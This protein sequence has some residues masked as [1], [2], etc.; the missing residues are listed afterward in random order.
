MRKRSQN[1][2]RLPFTSKT[3]YS[4]DTGGIL[5][6]YSC[7]RCS[8]TTGNDNKQK[9]KKDQID[10]LTN[11]HD[12]KYHST[13]HLKGLQF[14]MAFHLSELTGQSAGFLSQR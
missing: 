8:R 14:F 7:M 13:K 3:P 6:K 9:D 12:K 2:F 5:L 11:N 4:S 10:I 1:H